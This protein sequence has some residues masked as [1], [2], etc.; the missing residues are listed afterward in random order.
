MW[1][2]KR[3]ASPKNTRDYLLV[4]PDA[5]TIVAKDHSD[6]VVTLPEGYKKL[7]ECT[8]KDYK[9]GM[10]LRYLRKRGITDDI[11]KE[12]DIGY[13]YRG[14][15]FNR[16]IVPSYDLNG[17]LT[18]FIARWFDEEKTKLKYL[19]PDAEKQ[20]IIF[21]EG[22]INWDATIYVVEGVT[23]HIVTPNSVPLL[24]KFISQELLEQLHDKAMGYIVIVLDD[25]AKTDTFRLYKE[26]NF[27][28]LRGRI[29]ICL[30]PNGYDPSL[31]FQK[32]G[33]QGIV[34]LLKTSREP[35]SQELTYLS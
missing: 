20:G 28:N 30:P 9:A 14:K 16:I 6:I 5:A 24:G 27:G 18:Y 12:F 33:A 17:R 29:K 19:N 32:L 25:D 31:I 13:T 35:T 11:I 26:L 4:K 23:D 1:L 7:S 22:K 3:Y 15:F 8:D 10:A 2:F 34:K 21:N